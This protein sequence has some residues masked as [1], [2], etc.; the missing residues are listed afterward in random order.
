MN[1]STGHGSKAFVTDFGLYHSGKGKINCE[2]TRTEQSCHQKICEML[3][4][5]KVGP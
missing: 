4:A 3:I 5:Q 1:P 2:P